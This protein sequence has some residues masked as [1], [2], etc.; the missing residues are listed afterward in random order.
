M[1]FHSWNEWIFP[2]GLM[3]GIELIPDD[4]LELNGD[5]AGIILDI[6][7]FRVFLVWRNK[8]AAG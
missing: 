7:F 2:R 1:E 5:D 3:L 6:F 8:K 4:L